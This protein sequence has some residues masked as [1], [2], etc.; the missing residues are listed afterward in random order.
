MQC[1]L[2][3]DFIALDLAWKVAQP[4]CGL[5]KICEREILYCV[6][7]VFSFHCYN[8]EGEGVDNV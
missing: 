2:E 8:S 5:Y 3:Y 4:L 7:N 6:L 1:F